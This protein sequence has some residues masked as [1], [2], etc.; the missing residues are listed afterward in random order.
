MSEQAISGAAQGA[1]QSAPSGIQL[2]LYRLGKNLRTPTPYLMTFGIFLWLL[3]YYLFTEGWKLPRFEK[4]PGPVEVVTEFISTDPV[5]G[6]S[7]FTEDF[8][9][10]V[11]VSCRRIFIAFCIATGLG[12]PLGLFMGWSRKFRDYTFPILETLRPIPILAWVPLAI[13][14]FAGFETPIIFLATLA[15]F[16]VTTLNT[17]LGVRS[18]DEAYFRAAG[19][20]GSKKRHVFWHVVVPGAMPFIFTGLQISIGVAWFSLVAAEMISGDF[21]LGYMINDSF[22]VNKYVS[23]VMA[24]ISLGFVGWATSAMVRWAGNRMMQWR[25]RALALE[26]R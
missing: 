2:Q 5:W 12:V 14:M 16:F 13:V 3:T 26:G 15:S 11:Y 20:L 8:H 17:L 25:V 18:I 24:M 19:C 9:T 6:T 1:A 22:M 7:L 10:N 21:G 23:M 4:I